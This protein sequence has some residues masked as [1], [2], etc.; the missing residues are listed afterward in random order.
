MRRIAIVLLLLSATLFAET[1]EAAYFR[2]MQAEEAG[3]IPSAI[4][5]F[6]DALSISGEYTDEIR[7]IL[8]DY[9]DALGIPASKRHKLLRKKVL[10]DPEEERSLSYRF[11]VDLSSVGLYYSASGEDVDYGSSLQGGVSAFLD[12]SSGD[13]IHSFGLNLLGDFNFYNEDMP[14]LDTN[15]WKGVVGL[16]YTLV[17]GSLLLDVG[18]DLNIYQQESVS[19]SFYAWM[20]YDFPKMGKHQFGA[21]LW[22]YDDLMGP[23]SLALY[24]IW[25]RSNTYG[26]SYSIMAG[27]RLEVDSTFDYISYKE[28]FDAALDQVEAE[29]NNYSSEGNPFEQC[30]ATY[31]EECFQWEIATMDSLNWVAQ[32][33]KLLSEINVKPT[34]YWTKWFGP[35]IRARAQYKFKNGISLETK[36][37]L[38]YSFVLD[39]ADAQYEKISKFTSV[40][41]GTFLWNLG[42]TELYLGLED[43]FRFYSLPEIYEKV[44][45]RY[46]TTARMKIGAKWEF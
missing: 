43:V 14:A 24:G 29:M 2:A 17:T 9:Y 12:Y 15:D 33:E 42:C 39:G 13:F 44:Y 34:R 25:R 20:E 28:R 18:V 3:D 30:L 35:S 22:A 5:A 1:Q 27:P 6:E 10:G 32:Y 31:G 38:F 4:K 21:A 46:N 11:L 7:E 19:P 36:L 45:S 37:N 26:F 16:E 23:M 40:W 41:N 8:N